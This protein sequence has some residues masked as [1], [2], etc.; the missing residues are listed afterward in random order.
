MELIKEANLDPQKQVL[1]Q[2]DTTKDGRATWNAFKA[3]LNKAATEQVEKSPSKGGHRGGR[4]PGL[5][6]GS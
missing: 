3:H 2:L 5:C 4:K 1:E 6:C